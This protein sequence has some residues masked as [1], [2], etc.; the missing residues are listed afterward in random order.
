[1]ADGY[2]KAEDGRIEKDP[3]RRVQ[4][5]IALVFRKFEELQS[6]RQVLLWFRHEQVVVPAVVQGHGKQTTEWKAPVY[7]TLH[8]VLTNPVYA[9]AYVFG[10][11]GTRVVIEGGRKPWCA[12]VCVGTGRTGGFDPRPSRGIYFLGGVRKESASDRRQCQRKELFGPRGYPAR[13]S[14]AAWSVPLR[15]CGRRLHAAYTGKGG[16]TQRCVCR[17]PFG[18]KAV[19]NCIGF[20]GMRV[21]RAVAQ[22]V[23][24][25]L[26]PLGIEAALP[27]LEAQRQEH[28]DKRRQVENACRQAQYEVD[29]ARRQY[30][31]V[32]PD[33]RLV[34]GEL[35]RRWN[36]K[37]SRLR[38]LEDELDRFAAEQVPM[39]STEDRARLMELGKDVTR[40]WDSR[41]ASVE[42]RKKIIR[43]LV[44]EIRAGPGC[45]NRI[46]AS[47]GGAS[48]G[49]RPPRGAEE[50]RSRLD[51][52]CG[53]Q[54]SNVVVVRC[55]NRDT[56]QSNVAPH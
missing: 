26:Q 19:N 33:N 49:V 38:E 47:I 31:A 10:R 11:R 22:E 53:R 56:G 30:D 15:Y 25:G 6:I 12:T 9:G 3:D 20:G 55:K 37:L 2:V 44:R 14:S 18:A 42:T 13:R 51:P 39:V 7:Y 1:M 23:L 43:L 5:S 32:D 17:R 45:L 40:A 50:D 29:R 48:A 24:D 41:G 35:E 36:E 52:G 4:D 28:S 8:H 21:D 27:V 46:S 16:N 34:A 54:G